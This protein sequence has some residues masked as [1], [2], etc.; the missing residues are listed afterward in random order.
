M[1]GSCLEN[2]GLN[3]E[4]RLYFILSWEPTYYWLEEH[5]QAHPSE[6]QLLGN[7]LSRKEQTNHRW[8]TQIL[9][10]YTQWMTRKKN[11]KIHWNNTTLNNASFMARVAFSH[12]LPGSTGK[13]QRIDIVRQSWETQSTQAFWIPKWVHR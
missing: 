13:E 4:S 12:I 3:L 9:A 11:A 5:M 1:V 8:K 10:W 7:Y 6:G 2:W